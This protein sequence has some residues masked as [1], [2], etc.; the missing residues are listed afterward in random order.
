MGRKGAYR[1]PSAI[2]ADSPALT[3]PPATTRSATP[4]GTPVPRIRMH[5]APGVPLPACRTTC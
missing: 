2:L 5:S 4:P 3:H 1:F